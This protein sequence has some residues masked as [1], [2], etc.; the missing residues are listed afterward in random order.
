MSGSVPLWDF[1]LMSFLSHPPIS[2]PYNMPQK[3][4]YT[5]MGQVTDPLRL[6]Y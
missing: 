1:A 6:V 3:Q 2:S 4:V 5:V